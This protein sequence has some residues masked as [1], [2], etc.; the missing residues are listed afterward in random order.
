MPSSL[1]GLVIVIVAILPGSMYV[2][3]YER[4]VSAFGATLSDRVFRFIGVSLLLHLV[5]GWAEFAVYRST[6]PIEAPIGPA[7]FTLLWLAVLV[8]SALPFL[9]G[10]VIGGLY[11]SRAERD[12]YWGWLR[13]WFS[14]DS[15]ERLLRIALGRTPAPRAWDHLFSERPNVYLR[16]TTVD[17]TVF[18]GV[19]AQASY[20]GAFPHDADLY[21]QEAY[22]VEPDGSLS[23]QGLGYAVYVAGGQIATLEVLRPL[24]SQEVAHEQ[25]T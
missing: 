7:D 14:E 10:M 21:L 3:A 2:W 5:L 24:A 18:V 16:G 13:R 12:H 11:A 4:Q 17:G 25:V 1:V 6:W 9:V 8:L 15:E 20:A 23:E 19:F 22:Q